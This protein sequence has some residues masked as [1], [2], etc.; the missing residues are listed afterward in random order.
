MLHREKERI[1]AIAMRK[2]GLSYSEI[3][4]EVKVAKS[5]LSLWLRSVSLTKRQ[6]QRLTDKKRAAQER[7][8]RKVHEQ[9]VEKTK[10]IKEKAWKEVGN[11][12]VDPLWVAG[13]A[14]YWAEGS[15]EK[16]WTKDAKMTFSN[17]D[18][19]AHQ[20]FIKWVK[21]YLQVENGSLKYELYIHEK[22][23]IES[24]KKFWMD[25]FKIS[26]RQ[27]RVYFKKHNPRAKRKNNGDKYRGTARVVIARSTDL[28]RK[29]AGW[30]EGMIKCLT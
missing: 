18:L 29:I 16:D 8:W 5:T 10:L 4:S 2:N 21:K 20:L 7:G 22:A 12:I 9:R 27:L 13:L 30:V 11:F 24:A 14:L 3:L 26:H 1:K 19:N 25:G 28:N 15:K 17:M 23:N 6:V